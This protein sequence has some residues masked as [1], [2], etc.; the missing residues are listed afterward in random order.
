MV[1]MLNTANPLRR[2]KGVEKPPRPR[3][4]IETLSPGARHRNPARGADPR[5]GRHTRRGAT[6]ACPA[7]RSGAPPP[8]LLHGKI[9]GGRPW[10]SR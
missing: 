3:V 5:G 8:L 2:E 6:P 9:Q 4:S 1:S 7:P 10:R